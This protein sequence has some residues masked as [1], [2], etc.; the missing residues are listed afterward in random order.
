MKAE[1]GKSRIFEA[2]AYANDRPGRLK[3][4]GATTPLG[5]ARAQDSRS[6][7]PGEGLAAPAREGAAPVSYWGI[8][9][10]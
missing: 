7:R 5:F 8:A 6:K 9:I 1:G 10:S 3:A 2:G 4:A